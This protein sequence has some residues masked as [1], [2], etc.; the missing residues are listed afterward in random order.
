MSKLVEIKMAT[1]VSVTVIL[2]SADLKKIEAALNDVTGGDPDFF[3][4]VFAIA[5]VSKL[6]KGAVIQWL[7][8]VAVL[9][10]FQLNLVAVRHAPEAMVSSVI[11]AGLYLDNGDGVR[12]IAVQENET[13]RPAPAPEPAAEVAWLA[14][15]VLDTPVRAGQRVYARGRDLIV[16]AMVN[17]GGE[18]IADGNIFVYAP[19]RGR[20]LAGAQGKT[21]ARIFAMDLEAELVSIAGIYRTFEDGYPDKLGKQPC[22]VQLHGS[23]LEFLKLSSGV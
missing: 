22:Q 2:Q 1:V 19:L 23:K 3:D 17:A 20:A 21:D 9:K 15:M 18:V 5:D 7:D 4:S 6:A 8:V 11:A 13:P 14:P 16:T 10:K 12:E